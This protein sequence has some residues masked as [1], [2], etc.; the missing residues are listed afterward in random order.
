MYLFMSTCA[1]VNAQSDHFA[2]EKRVAHYVRSA[3]HPAALQKAAALGA[4][5]VRLLNVVFRT[6]S[7]A[8]ES[9]E[10]RACECSEELPRAVHDR[11]LRERDACEVL[12]TD[13]KQLRESRHQPFDL[14]AAAPVE[15]AITAVT[16]RELEAEVMFLD[17]ATP[18]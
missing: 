14:L 7:R 8:E 5:V 16:D 17:R 9:G 10:L 3:C 2:D 15:R 1:V 12:N 4:Q 18:I 11:E 13:A 6:K